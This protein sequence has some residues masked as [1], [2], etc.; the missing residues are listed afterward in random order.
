MY[1]FK[2]FNFPFLWD[3]NLKDMPNRGALVFEI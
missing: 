1:I 3:G 2:G